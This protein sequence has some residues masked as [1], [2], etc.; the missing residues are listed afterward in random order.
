MTLAY[1]ELFKNGFYTLQSIIHTL[2][3]MIAY[4]KFKLETFSILFRKTYSKSCLNFETLYN[5]FYQSMLI[6]ERLHGINCNS[7]FKLLMLNLAIESYIYKKIRFFF[8][9]IQITLIQN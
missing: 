9:L 4:V 8:Y 2:Y 1:F 6:K 5:M 3:Y 7:F